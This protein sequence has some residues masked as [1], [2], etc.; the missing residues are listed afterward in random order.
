MQCHLVYKL[1]HL[2]S[3]VGA[4]IE[5]YGVL[6]RKESS[7]GRPDADHDIRPETGIKIGIGY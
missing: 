1:A 4:V 7:W 5:F 6:S 3:G 2:L